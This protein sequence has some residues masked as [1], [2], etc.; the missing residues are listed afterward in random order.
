MLIR[1]SLIELQAVDEEHI[2]NEAYRIGARWCSNLEQ[3]VARQFPAGLQ[4]VK[5]PN[6]MAVLRAS[7]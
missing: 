7:E 3:S 4:R 6:C 5:V 2:G 1:R